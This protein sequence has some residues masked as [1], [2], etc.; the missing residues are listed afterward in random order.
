MYTLKSLLLFFNGT[1]LFIQNP[2]KR[3][4]TKKSKKKDQT[5]RMNANRNFHF[6][7]SN[8]YDLFLHFFTLSCTLKTTTALNEMYVYDSLCMDQSGTSFLV[9][10]LDQSEAISKIM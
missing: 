9:I 6:L 10:S 1:P 5:A 8:I 4:S 2:Q 3:F 7:K